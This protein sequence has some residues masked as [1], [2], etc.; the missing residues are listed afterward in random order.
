[1]IDHWNRVEITTAIEANFRLPTTAESRRSAVRNWWERITGGFINCL[2]V[3]FGS[4][5]SRLKSYVRTWCWRCDQGGNRCAAQII[6]RAMLCQIIWANM[7]V[8]IW[9]RNCT[10]YVNVE[11]LIIQLDNIK[12][13]SRIVIIVITDHSLDLFGA[14]P[15]NNYIQM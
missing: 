5:D 13:L 2:R 6:L 15:S 11:W 10:V 14:F 3:I 7:R 9:H 8:L 4:L 12:C 1:M